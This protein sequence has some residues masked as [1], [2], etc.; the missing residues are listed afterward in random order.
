[1]LAEDAVALAGASAGDELGAGLVGM[2]D[3]NSDGYGELVVG[4]PGANNAPR[5]VYLIPGGPSQGGGVLTSQAWMTLTGGDDDDRAG[6]TLAVGDIDGDGNE[7][8]IIAASA[9]DT[10]AGRVH[11]VLGSDLSSGTYA[12]ADIN[13]VSYGGASINGYAGRALAS[14]GDIDGDGKHDLIIGGPGN[15]NGTTD[16]GEAW[17]VV[18]GESGNRALVNAA[19]SF[20]G[21]A[22]EQV[23]SSVGMADINNDGLF[24]LLIGVPGESTL[25]LGEGAVYIGISNH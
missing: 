18:S 5:G 4:A 23:G 6:E 9:E 17:A 11:V 2:I 21:T 20:Y 16:A 8:L 3:L 14:G 1:M 7:D 22:N 12:I 15:S 10:R 24:D 25:L 19:S 13:H